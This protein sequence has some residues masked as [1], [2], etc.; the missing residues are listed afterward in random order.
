M[1]SIKQSIYDY[2]LDYLILL[3]V[4]ILIRIYHIDTYDIW[5]DEI[6]TF[7]TNVNIKLSVRYA[8]IYAFVNRLYRSIFPEA[9]MYSHNCAPRIPASIFGI[10]ASVHVPRKVTRWPQ[11]RDSVCGA[12]SRPG[13]NS[14][15]R[16]PI[17]W[18]GNSRATT[19]TWPPQGSSFR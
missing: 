6:S 14:S 18:S 12:I 2:K 8:P 9:F 11:I 10:S 3:A 13:V 15:S 19:C 5:A 7:F 1:K 16:L 17:V 4:C